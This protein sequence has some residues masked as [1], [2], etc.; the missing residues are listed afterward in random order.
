MSEALA[1]AGF[2]WVCIDLQHGWLGLETLPAVIHA[3]AIAG[4]APVVRVPANELWMIGRALDGGAY[5]VMVPLV[6]T[7]DEAR[8]AVSACR[9][10]PQGRRSYGAFRTAPLIAGSAPEVNREVVCMVQVESRSA[11]DELDGICTVPGIDAVYIGPSDLALSLGLSSG[12]NHDPRTLLAIRDTAR[13]HGVAAG[14]H[15]ESGEEARWAIDNGF[16]ITTAGADVDYLHQAA[17]RAFV[18]AVGDDPDPSAAR[19]R[20]DRAPR[21]AV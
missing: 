6:D 12:K 15:G 4:A 21:L 14:M 20:L 5:G 2:D 1:L 3:V 11:L 17:R 9:Y 16:A 10:A 8:R 19:D 18:T 7:A 13:R